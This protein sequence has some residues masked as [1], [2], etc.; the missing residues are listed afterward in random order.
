[1][2]SGGVVIRPCGRELL[3]QLVELWKEYVVDQNEESP[4]L[5]YFDLEASTEG[6][7]KIM[8]SYMEK[9]PGGFLV[10]TLG[11]EAVGFSVSF[12]EAFGPNYVTR[13]R[14]GHVQVVHTKRGFRRR[15]IA[16]K[17]VNAAID[18]LREN[19][20]LR[21]LADT[22]ETNTRSIKMLEKLDFKRFGKLV[23]FMR[24]I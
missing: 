19:G 23:N 10:A 12:K 17:L 11:G 5:P 21:V 4:L 16:T 15:G 20:C 2:S 9:E 7:H 8:E 1:M 24:E 22:G 13:E 14:V 6:F 3:P 18:Y